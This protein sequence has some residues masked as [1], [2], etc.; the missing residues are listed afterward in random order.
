MEQIMGEKLL[1]DYAG[2]RL[3]TD[4][5]TCANRPAELFIAVLA[6]RGYTYVEASENQQKTSQIIYINGTGHIPIP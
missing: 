4:R 3:L 1:I 2:D 6:G 5:Q